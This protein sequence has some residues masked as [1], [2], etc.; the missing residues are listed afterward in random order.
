MSALT[1]SWNAGACHAAVR[2]RAIVLRM[3]VSGTDSTS[4]D[5][6]ATRRRLARS[7]SRP[8][9]RSTSS[10]TIRPSGP[11]PR[12]DDSSIAA[13]ARDP[14]RER[15]GLDPAAVRLDSGRGSGADRGVETRAVS[16]TCFA[17]LR[18]PCGVTER[19]PARQRPPRPPRR[20]TRSSGRPAP[21]R[22]RA[23]SS[24]ARRRSPTR[25]PASPCR[26]RSRRAARPSRR[27][28]PSAFSH[29][30]T[31]PASM[32]WPSRGSLTWFAIGY[33]FPTVRRIAVE[34]VGH[35]R[36]HVLLHHRRERERRELRADA[37]DR[38]VEPVERLVLQHGRHLGAEAHARHG[39]VRDDRAVRLLHAARRAP[40]RRAAAACAG[41]SP[42]PRCRRPRRAIGRLERAVHQRPHRDHASRRC[43]RGSHAPCRSGSARA[44]PAPRP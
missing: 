1:V 20:S 9:A 19:R 36:D 18:R 27:V 44:P 5:G 33:A 26:C 11:V 34:H 35:L 24:A 41:R 6:T 39:L 7:S 29:L 17:P 14:A 30:V 28:S 3:L 21:R 25:P 12:S 13:L 23:R 32:P 43:P 22:P 16:D 8:A 42:R 38:R 15:R 2:R 4:P 37:L 31:V 10:A 40:P